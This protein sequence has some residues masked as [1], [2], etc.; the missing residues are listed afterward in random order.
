MAAAKVHSCGQ[1]PAAPRRR[2]TLL[3]TATP[4]T[5]NNKL[6]A[7]PARLRALRGT[8]MSMVFQE[9]MTALNPVMTVGD[10][11]EEVLQIHT[12]LS[13]RERR[14]RERLAR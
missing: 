1:D 12:R 13:E 14:Q 7:P 6:G 8:R 3:S 5:S 11:I 10:Q 2:S 4:A 9:P